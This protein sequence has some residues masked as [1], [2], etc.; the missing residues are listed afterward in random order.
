MCKPRQ[1]L[2]VP[3]LSLQTIPKSSNSGALAQSRFNMTH[4]REGLTQS[5]SKSRLDDRKACTK[6]KRHRTNRVKTLQITH[7]LSLRH[8]ICTSRCPLRRLKSSRPRGQPLAQPSRATIIGCLVRDRSWRHRGTRSVRVW[9]QALWLH[10]LS[11][12]SAC[13]KKIEA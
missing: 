8:N 6:K 1:V 10:L 2:A 13:N 12:A 5:L 7:S 11:I 3:L 4:C 9:I